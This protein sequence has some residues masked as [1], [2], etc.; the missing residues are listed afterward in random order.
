MVSEKAINLIWL[1]M[2]F[3]SGGGGS[4]GPQFD[5]GLPDR[6]CI[7]SNRYTPFCVRQFANRA[8][9]C[10]DSRVPIVLQIL[11]VNIKGELRAWQNL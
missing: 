4:L 11:V 5:Y 3:F 2:M 7:F 6:F 10:L 1:D 9:I 8:V